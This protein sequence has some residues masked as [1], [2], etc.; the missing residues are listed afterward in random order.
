M[1]PSPMYCNVNYKGIVTNGT[2]MVI[3]IVTNGT[4]MVMVI[5]FVTNCT[6]IGKV[7]SPKYKL[8]FKLNISTLH[9]VCIVC[10]AHHHHHRHHC[11]HH[12]ND[13]SQSTSKL[14]WTSSLREYLKPWIS[15]QLFYLFRHCGDNDNVDDDPDEHDDDQL[16]MQRQLD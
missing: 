6:V 2:V 9:Q 3:F 7:M 16:V 11:C 10:T 4:A 12:H 5:G 8:I 1:A 13:F 14:V 15:T